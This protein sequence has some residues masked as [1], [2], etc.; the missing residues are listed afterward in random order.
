M[1]KHFWNWRPYSSQKKQYNFRS[2]II[3]ALQQKLTF[4]FT[5]SEIVI[6]ALPL[7]EMLLVE[8]QWPGLNNTD[9]SIKHPLVEY[10][11]I[12]C[13]FNTNVVK[14]TLCGFS[15]CHLK[16]PTSS[17]VF[18]FQRAEIDHRGRAGRNFPATCHSVV[19]GKAV[20]EC[21]SIGPWSFRR[22]V[23]DWFLISC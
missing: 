9:H 3:P 16:E 17:K 5:F 10:N 2:E 6:L 14:P 8:S 20:R 11:L 13:S 15:L 4:G 21:S 1:A 12:P 23:K 7:S 19:T 22:K 18:I